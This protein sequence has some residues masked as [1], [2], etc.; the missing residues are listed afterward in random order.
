MDRD[1]IV[2]EVRRIREEQAA[3]CD[4]DIQRILSAA[5][6]RQKKSGFKMVSFVEDKA[7]S[8][9]TSILSTTK[10]TVGGI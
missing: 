8:G 1:Y 10:R 9:N 4:F 7:Y 2:E 3:K 5:K 6:K